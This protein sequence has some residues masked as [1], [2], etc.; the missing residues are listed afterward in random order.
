MVHC[1]KRLWYQQEWWQYNHQ[2]ITKGGNLRISSSLCI[3]H[4]PPFNFAMAISRRSD[5]TGALPHQTTVSEDWIY[6]GSQISNA[7]KTMTRSLNTEKPY[8]LSLSKL[9]LCKVCSIFPSGSCPHGLPSGW[10]MP[11]IRG[12]PQGIQW[13]FLDYRHVAS[14]SHSQSQMKSHWLWWM[15]L[16]YWWLQLPIRN[17]ENQFTSNSLCADWH[18]I[19]AR[20]AWETRTEIC[21]N[22]CKGWGD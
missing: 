20:T 11:L 18:I 2:G 8:S 4:S 6:Y 1:I 16:Q 17:T 22:N 7:S 3:Q 9:Y 19:T 15:S 10:Q 13:L 12:Q 21:N 14:Q 5:S